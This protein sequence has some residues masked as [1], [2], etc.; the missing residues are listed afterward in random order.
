[1]QDCSHCIELFIRRFEK[2][3]TAVELQTTT[4]CEGAPD[5]NRIKSF[6]YRFGL[7]D[8]LV[9]KWSRP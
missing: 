9:S 8:M 5:C 7:A 6:T 4:Y 2:E 3:L 1:V